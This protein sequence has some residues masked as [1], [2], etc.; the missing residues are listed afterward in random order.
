M[1]EIPSKDKLPAFLYTVLEKEGVK[2]ILDLSCGIGKLSV[3]LYQSGYSVVG[4]D[5][6]PEAI[7]KAKAEAQKIFNPSSK[8]YLRFY[9]GDIHDLQ[10]EDAP[11]DAVLMQLVISIIG[12][13]ENRKLLLQT[14]R[15]LLKRGGLLYLSASGVSDNINPK[16]AETYKRDFPTTGE[17]YTYFSKD[18]EGR[19][20]YVT[21]H[22]TEKELEKLLQ[23]DFK[24]IKIRKEKEASS[25][26]H[27]E[28]AYF[29]YATAE[30]K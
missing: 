29:L 27:D 2:T 5:I 15:N 10:L 28:A 22:F 23:P 9:V 14:G 7:A 25:R 19:I 6:N 16:Y 11:F 1:D 3:E 4:I 8:N 30:A 21:H 20:L 17:M 12:G 26:R 13:V 24:H 18:S